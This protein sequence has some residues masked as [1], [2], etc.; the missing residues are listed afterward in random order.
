M[1]NLEMLSEYS[2]CTVLSHSIA[3][4]H[5]NRNRKCRFSK[6]SMINLIF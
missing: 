3:V 5:N 4:G 6:D 2:P 1:F